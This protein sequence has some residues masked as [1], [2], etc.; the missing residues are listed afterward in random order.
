MK[1]D[2]REICVSIDA[3]DKSIMRSFFLSLSVVNAGFA[4]DAADVSLFLSS[5]SSS[6]SLMAE[7]FSGFS[8]DLY[9]KR[10]V[11][12]LSGEIEYLYM[13]KSRVI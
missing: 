7:L 5:S 2:S 9:R 10:M 4:S 6:S 11:T 1:P 12:I 13:F 8:S 3:F